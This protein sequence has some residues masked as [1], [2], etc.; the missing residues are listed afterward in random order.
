MPLTSLNC[1]VTRMRDLSPLAG[2]PLTELYCHALPVSDLSPLQGMPL[3]KLDFHWTQVAD[4]SPL[5]KMPLKS[6]VCYHTAVSDLSS[7]KGMKLSELDCGQTQV[8]D[9]SALEGMPLEHVLFG[10]SPISDL[11]PLKKSPL[12]VLACDGTHVSDLSPL[13]GMS[14]E[15]I[16]ITASDITKGTD[17]IRQMKSLAIIGTTGGHPLPPAEFWKKY[18]AGEFSQPS[19][20]AKSA[21]DDPAFQKWIKDVAALPAEEQ[22]KAVAK[23]LQEINPG[24]DGTETHKFEN[25][26]VTE[27]QFVTDHVTD[28]SPLRAIAGLKMLE[29][30]GSGHGPGKLS[31]L[32]PLQGM[33]LVKF[34][35]EFTTVSDLSPLRGAPLTELNCKWTAVTDLA[36][37]QGMPLTKLEC[38]HSK[39]STLSPLQGMHLAYI[40]CGG[41]AVS[42]LSPLQ[43]M[44]LRELRCGPSQVSDLAPLKGM[45]LDAL[46]CYGTNVSDLTPLDG[47]NLTEARFT[48]QN[49]AKGMNVIRQMKSLQVI[50]ISNEI[51]FPADDF[52]KKYDAGEFGKPLAAANL[53]LDDPAF[54]KWIKDVAALPAEGQVKE[55]VKKLQ[56]HNPGYDGKET[57]KI[58]NG[59]VAELK[60]NSDNVSNIL[61]VRALAGLSRFD[62]SGDR[63]KAKLSD[64]S[65]LR[66]MPLTV[67]FCNGNPVVDLSPVAG[68]SLHAAQPRKHRRRRIVSAQRHA[69]NV[70]GSARLTR[71]P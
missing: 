26:V 27:L 49:I 38:Q 62:C 21:L 46:F 66:G 48:P 19:A 11:S 60:F 70:P 20:A 14:I 50:G 56:E 65:A 64:L 10:G 17:A 29:C 33:K 13:Q 43:G 61:P 51:K 15:Q 22:V 4:L 35:C 32:S 55:V 44:P 69:A 23:K 25:G 54:Q 41:T 5:R 39:V 18:D 34:R 63:R 9:L 8:P 24:F 6:L 2:L 58:E 67:L 30:S 12:R 71:S 7:L 31:D 53:S 1:G 40:D 42:H 52:W 68:A 28:I 45:P 3:T 37:L 36:P 47:V 16:F 59:A 57:H